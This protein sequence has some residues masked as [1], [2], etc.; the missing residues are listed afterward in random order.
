MDFIIL[1]PPRP[2]NFYFYIFSRGSQQAGS[3]IHL[4]YKGAQ[5]LTAIQMVLHLDKKIL[6]SIYLHKCLPGDIE[7]HLS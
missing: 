5:W 6:V 7:A 2:Q 4:L 3:F 1:F